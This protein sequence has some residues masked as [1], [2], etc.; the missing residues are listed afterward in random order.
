M[1]GKCFTILNM[2]NMLC[3]MQGMSCAVSSKSRLETEQPLVYISHAQ[4]ES[5]LIQTAES[6]Y[7]LQIDIFISLYLVQHFICLGLIV[8]FCKQFLLQQVDG[9]VCLHY[10]YDRGVSRLIKTGSSLIQMIPHSLQCAR[11]SFGPHSLV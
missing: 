2:Y 5:Q 10:L 7:W 8:T 1:S 6:N 4:D 3:F 11:I 9:G